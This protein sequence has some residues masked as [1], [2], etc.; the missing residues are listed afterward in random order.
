MKREAQLM[1]TNTHDALRGLSRSPNIVPFHMLGIFLL[2]NI[3]FVLQTRC[4]SDVRLQKN[5][6]TL[7]SGSEVTE[8]H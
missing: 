2:C 1:L 6:M 4:F 3:N 8:G 5:V 7:K